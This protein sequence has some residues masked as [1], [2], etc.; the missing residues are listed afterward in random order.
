LA[1]VLVAALVA[2]VFWHHDNQV[3]ELR[4]QVVAGEL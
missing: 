2:A 1:I 3:S 4:T